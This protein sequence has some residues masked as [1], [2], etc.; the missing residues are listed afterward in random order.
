ML[1]CFHARLPEETSVAVGNNG[2]S[3]ANVSGITGVTLSVSC[4]WFT[5]MQA[6]IVHVQFITA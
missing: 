2:V 1:K 4:F 6:N 5:S 3:K